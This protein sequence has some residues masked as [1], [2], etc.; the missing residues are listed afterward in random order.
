MHEK[1]EK[2]ITKF[3]LGVRILVRVV[4]L[5]R[6][7]DAD[8]LVKRGL[9]D[10]I[11]VLASNEG[12]LLL[13]DGG[14]LE[15][16]QQRFAWMVVRRLHSSRSTQLTKPHELPPVPPV[17]VVVQSEVARARALFASGRG[18]FLDVSPFLLDQ[19]AKR[20][21]AS[22]SPV[23]REARLTRRAVCDDVKLRNEVAE[24]DQPREPRDDVARAVAQSVSEVLVPFTRDVVD[25][26]DVRDGR[27]M[28]ERSV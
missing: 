9:V 26:V 25:D 17:P 27:E 16:A 8:P 12:H 21:A 18:D 6:S 1:E 5:P 2:K 4:L 10:S 19:L 3:R 24:F 20:A 23:E 13:P 11:V 22:A 7:L 15:R 28:T 14:G